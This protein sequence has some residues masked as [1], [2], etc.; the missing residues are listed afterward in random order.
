MSKEEELEEERAVA[1][2]EQE[3]KQEEEVDKGEGQADRKEGAGEEQTKEALDASRR[4]KRDGISASHSSSIYISCVSEVD[5]LGTQSYQTSAGHTP[6]PPVV[7]AA[8]LGPALGEDL[9][10]SNRTLTTEHAQTAYGGSNGEVENGQTGQLP[11]AVGQDTSP[12]KF[13]N[14]L[15]KCDAEES[16]IVRPKPRVASSSSSNNYHAISQ[17][18]EAPPPPHQWPKTRTDTVSST[19]LTAGRGE[20]RPHAPIAAATATTTSPSLSPSPLGDMPEDPGPLQSFLFPVSNSPMDVIC[21]LSRL[22]AFTGELLAVLT[23]KIRKTHYNNSKVT[24]ALNSSLHA[25]CRIAVPCHHWRG[26]AK[27]LV[28]LS[29]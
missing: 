10:A 16:D 21:M 2:V 22:A 4:E 24:C 20:G 29:M 27:H 3:A 5:A 1:E 15:D 11:V 7:T 25:C 23:P 18:H 9:E 28:C 19:D 26:S 12:Q 8:G 13:N 6:Q 17:P 14:L